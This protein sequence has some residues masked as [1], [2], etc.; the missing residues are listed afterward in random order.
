MK[1]GTRRPRRSGRDEEAR[2]HLQRAQALERAG[3]VAGAAK[4]YGIVADLQPRNVA[5]LA[6]LGLMLRMID[7]LEEARKVLQ[8]AVKIDPRHAESHVHLAMIQKLFREPERALESL[9]RA[10]WADPRDVRPHFGAFG[11]YE[12]MNRLDDAERVIKQAL[13]MSPNHERGIALLARLHRRR[14]DSAR[15]VEI[16]RTLLAGRMTDEARQFAIFELARNLE[17]LEDYDGAFASFRAANDLQSRSPMARAVDDRKWL[18]LIRDSHEFTEDHF[19]RW[20]AEPPLDDEPG[21]VFLFGFPRSGTTMTEQILAAHRDVAVSDEQDLFSP[22][23]RVMFPDWSD[24]EPLLPQLE[25]VPRELLVRARETYRRETKRLLRHEKG[26]TVLVDKNPMNIVALGIVSRVFPDA[27]VIIAQRDP[28]EV[29]L[30][31]FFQE[32]VPN[33]SNNYFFTPEGTLEMY[34]MVM[35]LWLAQRDILKLRLFECRYEV[36]T[37]DF[38]GQARRLIEFLGLPWDDA[39]LEFHTVRQNRYVSTPSFEAA[40]SPVHTKA[41]GKWRNYEAHIGPLL[42]G[43][44]PYLRAFGYDGERGADR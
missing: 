21:P 11:I 2:S 7:E 10:M 24:T 35:D 37:T 18:R 12:Q 5:V 26:A 40:T 27:R 4:E 39:V 44:A 1:P 43:L 38:E 32:F 19:A 8:Q 16:L 28:R 30:S 3:N 22:M 34:S 33:P 14:G 25:R 9:E 29:C 15:A 17:K 20:A 6:R 13:A 31:C 23:Y 41:R 42:E 36:T